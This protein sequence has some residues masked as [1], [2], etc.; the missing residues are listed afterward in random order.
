VEM[1]MQHQGAQCLTE[2]RCVAKRPPALPVHPYPSAGQA[3]V[4]DRDFP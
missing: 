4:L 1:K 3:R 2:I